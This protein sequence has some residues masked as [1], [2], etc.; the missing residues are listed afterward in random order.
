MEI[1]NPIGGNTKLIGF[2]LPSEKN[3]TL[4]KTLVQQLG[5]LQNFPRSK[6]KNYTSK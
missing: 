2:I 1:P 6:K 3:G 5:F 4:I